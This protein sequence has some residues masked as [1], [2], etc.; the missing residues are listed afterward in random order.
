MLKLERSAIKLGKEGMII[1]RPVES[2]TMV[3]NIKRNAFF[4]AIRILH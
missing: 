2:I 3:I 1:P 4:E